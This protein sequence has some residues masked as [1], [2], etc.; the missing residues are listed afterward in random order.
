VLWVEGDLTD[1]AKW[2]GDRYP[3]A[4]FEARLA[5][6]PNVQRETLSPCGHMLHLDQPEALATLMERFLGD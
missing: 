4:E 6:V 5:L 3:R 1:V 2:W